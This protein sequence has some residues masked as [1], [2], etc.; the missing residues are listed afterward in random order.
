MTFSLQIKS[1]PCDRKAFSISGFVI[2]PLAIY[3]FFLIGMIAIALYSTISQAQTY[4][5]RTVRIIVPVTSAG[6]TDVVSR[7]VAKR[8]SLLWSESVVVDNRPGGGSNLGFELAAQATPDG[9][10]LLMAQPAF[11]VNVSLYNKLGYQ[12]LRDFSAISQVATGANVLVVNPTLAAHTIMD[13]I[14]L[15]K[16]NP[17]HYNYASSGNGTSPHLSGELFKALA[18]VSITHIPYKGA[19]PSLTE[20]MGGHV[21][22]AFLSLS[23]VLAPLKSQRL[24]ALAI[25]SAQRS[26]LLPDIPTV[27]EAALPGFEITGWYGLVVRQGTPVAVITKIFTDLKRVLGDSEVVSTLNT[28]ALEASMS[29]S[30]Q[31][32]QLFLRTEIVK[33]AKVVKMAGAKTD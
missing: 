28:L 12:P 10:T 16:K 18:G 24:R 6:A 13:L 23:S 19:G 27:A 11:T 3:L 26:T 29:Q 8:L 22:M 30:P 17:G 7:T 1:A 2:S 33:W 5:S 21:D 4:P 32:F 14:A 25:T 9:Y 20:L 31:A 15:A